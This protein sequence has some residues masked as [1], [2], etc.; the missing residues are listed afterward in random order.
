[1][2]GIAC[3]DREAMLNGIGCTVSPFMPGMAWPFLGC[4]GHDFIP[5]WRILNIHDYGLIPA[6]YLQI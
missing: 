3:H 1:M 2:A 6:V 4:Q 5:T